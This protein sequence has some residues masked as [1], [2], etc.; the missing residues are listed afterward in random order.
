M[1]RS[2]KLIGLCAVLAVLA[3]GAVLVTKV[4]KKE[5]ASASEESGSFAVADYGEGGLSA[6]SF[7]ANGNDY[8]FAKSDG[9]WVKADSLAFPVN[10]TALSNLEKKITGMTAQRRL[11]GVTSPADYGLA[12]PAYAVTVKDA[13]GREIT[14]SMG[15]QTPFEDG[16]YLSVSDQDGVVYTIRDSLADLF[17]KRLSQLAVLETIPEVSDPTALRIGEA[18]DLAKNDA[19]EWTVKAT[20]EVLDSSLVDRL[21]DTV[22]G[23]TWNDLTAVDATEEQLQ[24]YGLAVGT[25]V[26]LTAADGTGLRLVLGS[27]N[28]DGDVYARLADAQMVYTIEKDDVSDVLSASVDTLWQKKPV[29]QAFDDLMEMTCTLEDG[30]TLTVTRTEQAPAETAAPESTAATETEGTDSPEETVSVVTNG[31]EDTAGTGEAIFRQLASLSG[32][33]RTEQTA[34]DAPVL[35]VKLTGSGWEKTLC[36]YWLDADSYLLPVT[37]TVSMKVPADSVDRLIRQ[38]RA[39]L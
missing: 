12:E 9:E 36:F 38:I 29:T 30:R 3:G 6:L 1:K 23:L 14:Y 31:A 20:G 28:D 26:E 8:A 19:G 27:E 22:S 18:V 25:E 4:T 17:D 7:S 21:A 37:Q 24:T 5:E 11:T 13:D 16:W 33:E 2:V 32:T 15:A 35:T 39:A 34:G 10:Q